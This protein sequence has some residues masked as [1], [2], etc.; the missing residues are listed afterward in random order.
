MA[1]KTVNIAPGQVV[2]RNSARRTLSFT[3]RSGAGQ[4]IYLTKGTYSGLATTNAEYVLSVGESLHFLLDWDG[5]DIQDEWGAMASADAATMYV[6][7]TSN[8]QGR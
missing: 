7:E 4:V 2:S 6:G 8:R 1:L 5:S 3:N